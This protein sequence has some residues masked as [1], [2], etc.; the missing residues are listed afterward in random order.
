VLWTGARGR[1]GYGLFYDAGQ[2]HPAHR[3]AYR[4]LVGPIPPGMELDHRFTS[5]VVSILN[6]SNPC[7]A[8]S[9]CGGCTVA[10]ERSSF[11]SCR[12][13]FAVRSHAGGCPCCQK[14]DALG[15][16]TC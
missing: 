13:G 15:D 10:V 8:K 1:D 7:L 6:I 9:I 16:D 14:G 11:I 2:M 4:R 5:G 12:I 3:W